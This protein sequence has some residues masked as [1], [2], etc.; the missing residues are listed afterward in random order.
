MWLAACGDPAPF[1]D[2]GPDAA[3]DA[4]P[5]DAS[6][7]DAP[8]PGL[9]AASDASTP[10]AAVADAGAPDAPQL[11]DAAPPDAAPPDA[12]LPDAGPPL[13]GFVITV[14]NREVAPNDFR[15]WLVRVP[16]DGGPAV[17]LTSPTGLCVG[18]F[19]VTPDGSFAVYRQGG[20]LFSVRTDGS[21]PPLQLSG[22]FTSGVDFTL[23]P[24]GD[25]VA[26]SWYPEKR[27][28]TV[29]LDGTGLVDVSG[30]RQVESPRWSPRGD[31]LV[32]EHTDDSVFGELMLTCPEQD[33]SRSILPGGP[34]AIV[35]FSPDGAYLAAT[36][37]WSGS[38]AELWTI[39]MATFATHRV[40]PAIY[41][42]SGSQRW[43]P[44]SRRLTYITGT[45]DVETLHVGCADGTCTST[46]VLPFI[47]AIRS[48]CTLGWSSDASHVIVEAQTANGQPLRLF[49]LCSDGTCVHEYPTTVDHGAKKGA[50]SPEGWVI[51]RGSLPG[52]STSEIVADCLDETCPRLSATQGGDSYLGPPRW[53]PGTNRFVAA[54]STGVVVSEGIGSIARQ[55]FASGRLLD[56]VSFDAGGQRVLFTDSS[57][58]VRSVRIDGSNLRDL[59]AAVTPSGHLDSFYL[60]VR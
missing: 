27:L 45:S 3:P 24:R 13:G 52:S 53:Y 58:H 35:G 43:S 1:A 16:L 22:P 2:A 34:A 7:P 25:R 57:Y 46:L 26:Y 4:R 6:G 47:G 39:D 30:G 12:A 28:Y 9:D 23:S 8:A 50:F 48:D 5:D 44:D 10:D 51:H 56:K 29:R 59:D 31:V 42:L 18:E 41:N 36:A 15:C 11:S 37:H 33:C 40:A 21:T 14:A 49:T 55:V 32:Y 20:M 19:E 54:G 17:N 60:V 38:Q